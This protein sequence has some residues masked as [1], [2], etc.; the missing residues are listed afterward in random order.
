MKDTYMSLY[1]MVYMLVATG[2][3][4]FNPFCFDYDCL[5]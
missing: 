2:K 3:L 5:M 4:L 1:V